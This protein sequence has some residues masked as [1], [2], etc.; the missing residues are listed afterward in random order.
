MICI[1]KTEY[2]A[3]SAE[4]MQFLLIQGTVEPALGRVSLGLLHHPPPSSQIPLKNIIALGLE[5]LAHYWTAER[6][7]VYIVFLLQVC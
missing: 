1:Q 4:T 6:A 7:V 2:N 5:G 3:V